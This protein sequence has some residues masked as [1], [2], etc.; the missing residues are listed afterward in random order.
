[1]QR[2]RHTL[3][4]AES[5]LRQQVIDQLVET[6]RHGQLLVPLQQPGVR[7]GVQKAC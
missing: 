7:R 2:V 1:M 6:R 5:D 3:N 4:A